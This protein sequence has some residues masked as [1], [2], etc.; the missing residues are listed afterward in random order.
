MRAG[1]VQL[2]STEDVDRNLET[3]R[4]AGPRRRPSGRRAG[5]AAR[6]VERARHRASRWPR[7][8]SRSTGRASTWARDVAREL[9]IDLSPA[10]SSSASTGREKTSNTSVHIGARRR[11]PRRVPQAP[12]VRRRGRRHASTPSPTTS[13]PATR[14]SSRALAGGMPGSGM[15]ICY[16]VRF[17]ELYRALAARGAQVIAVPT[18]FT[19]ATTRDH[20]EVLL[21]ARAIENQCFVV[22]R[23]PDRRRTRAGNRSG[24]RS[25]DRRSRGG[26]C[27]PPRPITRRRSSPSSTSPLLRD[28][29]RRLPSLTHRRPEAYG[30]GPS[31]R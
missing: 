6:E 25:T 24:G 14:S 3:R 5:R 21:R 10:R 15:S 8:R 22:A 19:L 13:S 12:H 17:P 23:Q 9:G 28:V 4:P 16:D 26:W 30:V 18:A 20:W 2:N 1:A 31:G 27:W 11:D 7:A 29:R